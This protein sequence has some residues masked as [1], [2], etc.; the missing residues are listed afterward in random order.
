MGSFLH[1][2]AGGGGGSSLPICPVPLSS[3]WNLTQEEPMDKACLSG[4]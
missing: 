3:F 2:K 1:S 4:S